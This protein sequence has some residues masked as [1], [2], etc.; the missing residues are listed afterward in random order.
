MKI[1]VISDI[2]SNIWALE[3]VLK[4]EKEYDLLCCA[5]D[6][7]DYGIA[8]SEVIHSIRSC[9]NRIVVQGNHDL[10]ITRMWEGSQYNNVEPMNFKWAHHNCQLLKK[11]AISY[12]ST[13][14]IHQF[15]KID[16]YVYMVQHQ[17][18][19]KYG[20]IE[21]S[22]A[23]DKYWEKY[24]P[25]KLWQ[26][27]RKRMIFGHTHRQGIYTLEQ[28][29]QWI[30]PGSISYRRPDDPDKT[31]HYAIIENGEIILRRTPYNRAPQ[32]VEAEKYEKER[33]MMLTEIQDFKFFFGNAK[34]P[35]DALA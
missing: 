15:F 6:L 17:Y 5:G 10:E 20:I 30:N 3:A 33:K 1:I 21:C 4:V 29:K 2:H 34:T 24:A 9:H 19:E 7:V 28:G 35:R 25:E 31:A 27:P 32:L 16:G 8:P 26:H 23:F 11:D 12:L 22:F 13:L 14:P 18:D